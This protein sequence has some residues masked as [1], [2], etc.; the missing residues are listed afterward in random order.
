MHMSNEEANFRRLVIKN[1]RNLA[2]FCLGTAEDSNEDKEFLTINRSLERDEL[3]GIVTLIGVNNSGKSN[4]L[5]ALEACGSQKFD[6]R[7]Y[8]DFLFTNR[9]KPSVSMNVANGMYGHNF[10]PPND[11]TCGT[12]LNGECLDVLFRIL[13]EDESYELYRKKVGRRKE[14]NPIENW[15]MEAYTQVFANKE[16]SGLIQ[17][18]LDMR[19]IK[20]DDGTS[21]RDYYDAII[22]GDKDSWKG[23]PINETVTVITDGTKMDCNG[24]SAALHVIN[25]VTEKPISSVK[26]TDGNITGMDDNGRSD[27]MRRYGYELCNDVLRYERRKIS[28]SEM[29]CDPSKPNWVEMTL[30]KHLGFD[31]GVLENAYSNSVLRPRVEKKI[32]EALAKL[33]DEFNDLLNIN[34]KRYSFAMRLEKDNMEVVL[35]YGDDVPLN[36]DRQ[37]EGF[38][39]LFDFYVGFML[40]NDLGPGSIVLI[41]EF[42]NSLGFSTIKELLKK[43]RKFARSRGITFV[44]ATQNPMAVDILHLD[45][46][47]LV[48]PMEDGSAH[49]VNNFDQFGSAGSH[50]V[51]GPVIS[52]LMV[53]RNFMRTEGRRTV[54]V[55]GATDY[56]YLNAFSEALRE[57]GKDIDVDF[58]PMNG[59]GS[60]EDAPT[61]VLSQIKSI[62]R[63]PT[64]FVDGDKAGEKFVSVASSKGIR[65]S[66]V[67]EIFDGGKKEIEDLFSDADAERFHV[68]DKSFDKAA[69]FSQRIG[70]IYDGID[71]ETKKNF[72]TAI[73]YIMAQ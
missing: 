38:R 17:F 18:I 27:F 34:E 28:R 59:L 22:G 11:V 65:P 35:S 48:V 41:D 53:S 69:C 66:S 31:R 9:I 46:I 55:E 7:D 13:M 1:Y 58:I 57:R 45:E 29:T 63:N 37:S 70:S 73:D 12:A 24:D 56:F 15:M 23:K 5:D 71:D 44:L 47:R 49:I 52:G 3:G 42:G 64:V 33:S 61:K 54:F 14:S 19:K 68:R 51:M 43:L 50:D 21:F 32:N 4:I 72:E 62:E 20:L 67:S 8:T 30:L 60:R 36:I 6:D 26:K 2:P 39:W 25:R 16:A 40:S 10:S